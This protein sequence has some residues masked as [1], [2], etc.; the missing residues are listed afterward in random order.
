ME[1][2]QATVNYTINDDGERWIVAFTDPSISCYYHSLIPKCMNV[3]RQATPA[4]ITIYRPEY[5]QIQDLKNWGRFNRKK[6]NFYYEP[7]IRCGKQYFWVNAF[8][9]EMEDIRREL[10]LSVEARYHTPPVGFNMFFHITIGNIKY[11][12]LYLR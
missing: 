7:I 12:Q 8:S 3:Q 9:T 11:D 10:G 1:Q 5:E 4:H 2:A 6:V